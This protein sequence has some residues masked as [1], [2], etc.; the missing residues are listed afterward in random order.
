[1]QTISKRMNV[2]D[3]WSTLVSVVCPREHVRVA[4]SHA[5]RRGYVTTRHGGDEDAITSGTQKRTV[6][7]INIARHMDQ[8][9]QSVL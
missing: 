6:T 4:M 7:A 5:G 3:M 1:M 8:H 2:F 9:H